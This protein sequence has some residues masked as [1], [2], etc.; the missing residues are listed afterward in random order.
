MGSGEGGG[1]QLQSIF[2][3]SIEGFIDGDMDL[4]TWTGNF[5]AAMQLNAP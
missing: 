1:V 4:N 2:M 3:D 5:T